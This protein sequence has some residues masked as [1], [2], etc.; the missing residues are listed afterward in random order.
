MASS[1]L[2][3]NLELLLERDHVTP[4]YLSNTS[5]IDKPVI[6]RILNGKTTNPQVDT[7]KPIAAFFNITIDQ[8]IGQ[9]ALSTDQT[10]GIVVP[11]NRLL[12]PLIE[13]KHAPYWLEIKNN[14]KPEKTIDAKTNSSKD[15]Y[16]LYIDHHSFEPRFA[17]NSIIIVDPRLKPGNRDYIIT[18]S[19]K[20]LASLKIEQVIT[21]DK[22][23]FLKS[24]S[25][26]MEMKKVS[27]IMSLGVIMESHLNLSV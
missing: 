18:Q 27:K 5:G 10:Y 11:I 14:Y 23:M 4:A 24:V 1:F 21:D 15:S 25:G 2:A 22:K 9:S 20:D 17:K 12:V 7:L 8:L 16:A 6:S 3:K 19:S 26:K 13:W